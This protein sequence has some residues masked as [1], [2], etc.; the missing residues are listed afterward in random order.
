MCAYD[1]VLYKILK[2][3]VKRKQ[4]FGFVCRPREKRVNFGLQRL[5]KKMNV[6]YLGFWDLRVLCTYT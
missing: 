5:E 3:N 6:Y 4:E 1:A 2:M